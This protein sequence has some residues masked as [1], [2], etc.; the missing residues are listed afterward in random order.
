VDHRTRSTYPSR[1]RQARAT[2]RAIVS[3]A[4]ELFVER[5]YAATTIDAVAERA[6]VGRKTVFSS[7]GG[8]GA[9][10]KLVWDWTLVGDDEPVPMVDR[11]AV[12]AMLAERDPH[13]LVRMWVDMQLEAVGRAS[14]IGAVVMAAADVDDEV[15][16][17]S[18]TIR[19][20]SLVGARG[21]ATHLAGTGG[22]R[23]GLTPERAADVCW[24]VVNSLLWHLLVSVRGWPASAYGDWL[25]D[26]MTATLLE[27]A[28]PAAS[29][30]GV[31]IVH[32]PDHGRY[33]ALVGGR[34]AGRL[35]YER[36]DRLVVL[37]ST[38]V[39]PAL[40]DLGVAGSLVQRALDDVRA[41]GATRV[42]TTCPFATWWLDRH[43]DYAD[44]RHAAG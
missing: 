42:L 6:G 15:R 37:T 13:R 2:R 31:R 9:L 5:G 3:A 14:P 27:P 23:K 34:P 12:R 36:T 4:G 35:A 25:V 30:P 17:L 18:E 22:L 41:E 10:L 26:A 19:R 16:E 29:R 8:K 44:L 40:E 32:E 1:E 28:E 43:P 21:F 24:A 33:E 39:D 20:E 11:P 7:V 38:E